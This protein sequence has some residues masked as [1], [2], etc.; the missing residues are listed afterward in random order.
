[1]RNRLSALEYAARFTA[2]KKLTGRKKKAAT[3]ALVDFL[4]GCTTL[5]KALVRRRA[6]QHLSSLVAKHTPDREVV[7]RCTWM[8]RFSSWVAD[9][10]D[11]IPD[12]LA[13]LKS[14]VSC[15]Q[16]SFRRMLLPEEWKVLLRYL[17]SAHHEPRMTPPA[18][19]RLLYATAI[20]TGLRNRELRKLQCRDLFLPPGGTPYL[21]VDDSTT[22]NGNAAKQYIRPEL[23]GELLLL[24]LGRP[25]SDPLFESIFWHQTRMLQ[26]DLAG[27]RKLWEAEG[28]NPADRDFLMSLDSRQKILC[29]HSLR[30]TC[31][32]W[33][34]Q[35]GE[36][37]KTVQE[38]MRHSSIK[39]TMDRYGHLWPN[40]AEDAISKMRVL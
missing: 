16:S 21:L 40:G 22:K 20:S 9:N 5:E 32:A 4:R 27:A 24:T 28:G 33:L 19:R 18:I 6:S 10:F 3:R 14:P 25:G 17:E 26:A 15:R 8:K 11:G 7:E 29:F 37:P 39:L 2:E 1:M 13:G 30:H 12:Q 35:Q 36:N 23:A 31:G 34:C 38:I